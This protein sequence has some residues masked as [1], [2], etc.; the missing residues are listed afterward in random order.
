MLIHLGALVDDPP[1]ASAAVTQSCPDTNAGGK[2]TCTFCVPCP[3]VTGA[4]D[5][6]NV[7]LYTVAPADAP[8]LYGWVVF[9][10]ATT[11]F[12][13]V[14]VP[15]TLTVPLINKHLLLLLPHPFTPCRHTW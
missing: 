6:P 5:P 1:Q 7:Q 13:G 3:D 14:M 4:A 15:G 12:A 2:V 9:G 10:H 11:P 8:Q